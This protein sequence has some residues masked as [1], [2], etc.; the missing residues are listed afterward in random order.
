LTP[1]RTRPRSDGAGESGHS[2]TD[3]NTVVL[4]A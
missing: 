3:Q 4:F 1:S 2:N